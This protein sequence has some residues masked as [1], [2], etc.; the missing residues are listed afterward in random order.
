MARIIRKNERSRYRKVAEF[1]CF[2]FS[3]RHKNRKPGFGPGS[4]G[5]AETFSLFGLLSS[6]QQPLTHLR[7]IL[8]GIWIRQCKK[9]GNFLRKW[10][11]THVFGRC[12]QRGRIIRRAKMKARRGRG[13]ARWQV[14]K[15]L[16]LA[17]S[18]LG[19][20]AKSGLAK[21]SRAMFAGQ[22]NS[23]FIATADV[24][25]SKSSIRNEAAMSSPHDGPSALVHSL[26]LSKRPCQ[27][28]IA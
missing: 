13:N 21:Y 23:R 4:Q 26:S 5:R 12:R 15:D 27:T 9:T 22:R 2:I 28:S 24:F 17:P 7:S 20:T 18:N 3:E 11:N 8:R 1:N 10:V 16:C 14:S 19:L 6:P 25:G